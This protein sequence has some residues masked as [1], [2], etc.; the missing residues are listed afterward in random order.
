MRM[1]TMEVGPLNQGFWKPIKVITVE[2]V[3]HPE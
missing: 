2:R 1:P 3:V